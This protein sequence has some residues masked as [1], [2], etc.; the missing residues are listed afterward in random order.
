MEAGKSSFEFWVDRVFCL[1]N[2]KKKT[3]NSMQYCAN[4]CVSC[5]IFKRKK[6]KKNENGTR[7]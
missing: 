5:K 4:Y 7:H 2:Q 3:Q 1:I 6:K